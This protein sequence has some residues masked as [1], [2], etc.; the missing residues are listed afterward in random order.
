MAIP[1]H[2]NNDLNNM[3]EVERANTS[4][5]L[6]HREQREGNLSEILSFSN[7]PQNHHLSHAPVLISIPSQDE[8]ITRSSRESVLQRLSEALLRRSLAKV[9]LIILRLKKV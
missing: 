9:S 4:N 3:L 8:Y 2:Q 7:G 1:P 6:S 5:P